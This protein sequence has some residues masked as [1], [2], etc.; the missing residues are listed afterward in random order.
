[1][2]IPFF[3]RLAGDRRRLALVVASVVGVAA[4]AAFAFSG[5]GASEI[6]FRT[7]KVERGGVIRTVSASGKLNPVTT[8]TIGSQV[9]GKI[10][11]V[12]V[13]YNSPVRAGEV[14]ARIDPE[15]FAAKMRESR[16]ELAVTQAAQLNRA[17]ALTRAIAEHENT[18]AS[19]A[20]NMADVTKAEVQLVDLEQDFKRK[21]TLRKEGFTAESALDKARAA[22]RT[23]QAELAS[24]RARVLAQKS[25]IGSRAAEIKIAEAEVAEAAAQAQKAEATLKQAEV[26]LEYTYI[27]SPVDGTVIDRA[28][29]VGQTVAASLQAPI[30]F[31]I[32]KDL[33]EMQVETSIDEADIGQVAVGQPAS[34]EVDAFPDRKFAGAVRQ[35]RKLA[36]E[37]EN[38]VTYTVVVRAG[39]PNLRLLPGMTAQVQIQI[40]RLDG[41]LK[42]PNAALRYRPAGAAMDPPAVA[43]A[44]DPDA[45]RAE[46]ATRVAERSR[47][48]LERLAKTLSLTKA[49]VEQVGALQTELRR[50]NDGLREGGM[51]REAR[52][53]ETAALRTKYEQDLMALLD[54]R[55]REAYRKITERRAS[56]RRGTQRGR[57]WVLRNGEATEVPVRVGA[58]DGSFTAVVG[59]ALREGDEVIVGTRLPTRSAGAGSNPFRGFRL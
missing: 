41:I 21:Q 38:V 5:N 14:I 34:F 47:E 53:K 20:A 8:V 50:R 32:A 16:A 57:L 43:D 45:A 15:S 9:S 36:K 4:L 25:L 28:V 33:R 55:Q 58:S 44:A 6:V 40:T 12:L 31:T 51:E 59:G 3:G 30:L 24:A 7:A 49:Q 27:R 2:R 22:F 37:T 10:K 17:A 54:S 39:N 46:R 52:R 11:E 1:M 29:D 18:R 26:N 13:D 56:S 19:L 42:V 23:A 35:V 48:Q